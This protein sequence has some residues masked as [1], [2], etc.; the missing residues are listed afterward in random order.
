MNAIYCQKCGC[1]NEYRA[2]PTKFCGKCGNDMSILLKDDGEQPAPRTRRQKPVERVSR[3]SA[4]RKDR[5]KEESFEGCSEIED[6]DI[7]S[8]DLG[9]VIAVTEDKDSVS[10]S[11]SLKIGVPQNEKE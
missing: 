8:L 7:D 2:V 11:F 6:I 5:T 10:S 3:P 1:K 9:E 4:R